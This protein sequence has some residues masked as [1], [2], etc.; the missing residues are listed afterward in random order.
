[1]EGT[2]RWTKISRIEIRAITIFFQ[3]FFEIYPN[4]YV[5]NVLMY[6]NIRILIANIPC[7]WKSQDSCFYW[8]ITNTDIFYHHYRRPRV[9]Y[10]WISYQQVFWKQLKCYSGVPMHHHL[11]EGTW[12]GCCLKKSRNWALWCILVALAAVLDSLESRSISVHRCKSIIHQ[13]SL[14][15]VQKHFGNSISLLNSFLFHL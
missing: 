10:F 5:F 2:E 15:L 12:V 13:Q 8:L 7:G 6:F 3:F 1:M 9:S 14:Y 4:L 11:T